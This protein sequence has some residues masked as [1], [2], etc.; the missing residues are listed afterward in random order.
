MIFGAG[1]HAAQVLCSAIE[2]KMTVEGYISTDSPGT[3]INE[4]KVLGDVEFFLKND[5]L[6]SCKINIAIGEN[7]VRYNIYN[8]I[9]TYKNNLFTVI[10]PKVHLGSNLKLANGSS[11]MPLAIINDYAQIGDCCIIDSGA[12]VEHH[13][14]IGNFVNVSPGSVICGGA[15]IEDGAIVGASATVIEK[16][17]IGK[18]SLIGAGAVV[19]SDIPENSVAIG[20]PAKVTRSR[21]FNDR[22]LK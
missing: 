20:N 6:H 4:K 15:V 16:I 10:S 18:N 5:K 7:S 12:I 11:I 1:G 8:K 2:N 13:V 9:N 17:R 3:I 22:Y 14:K 21:N 19:V